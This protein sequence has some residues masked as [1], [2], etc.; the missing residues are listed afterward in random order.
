MVNKLIFEFIF[1]LEPELEF[2]NKIFSRVLNI[3]FSERNWTPPYQTTPLAKQ[4]F[5]FILCRQKL[6]LF[7]ILLYKKAI[8]IV[9]NNAES[10]TGDGVFVCGYS[11]LKISINK[12]KTANNNTAFL[13]NNIVFFIQKTT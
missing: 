12:K 9:A 3:E 10:P 2:F 11:D 5:E 1:F 7:A 13:I 4:L 6:N 8:K